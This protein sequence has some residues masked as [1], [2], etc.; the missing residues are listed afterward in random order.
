MDKDLSGS[1][2]ER[3]LI[4]WG[5]AKKAWPLCLFYS[6]RGFYFLALRKIWL[7]V[8]QYNIVI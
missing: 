7:K 6:S 5:R 1:E 3:S 8:I 2:I 4:G